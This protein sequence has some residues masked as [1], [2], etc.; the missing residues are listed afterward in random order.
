[1]ENGHASPILQTLVLSLCQLMTQN[2]HL[3]AN[4]CKRKTYLVLQSS[5]KSL[6]T[7]DCHGYEKPT[8]FSGVR[9][10]VG[11]SVPCENPY[12]CHGYMGLIRIRTPLK[13]DINV[14]Q[15]CHLSP[16]PLLEMSIH[17]CFQ[18]FLTSFVHHHHLCPSNGHSH[19][20]TKCT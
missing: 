2:E 6:G 15:Y 18:V 20:T 19:P 16:L 17:A 9:V 1:M 7:R 13:N 11:N 10:W 14:S 3:H 12:L 4:L 8:G 5:G